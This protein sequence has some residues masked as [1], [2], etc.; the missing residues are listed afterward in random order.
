MLDLSV[1]ELAAWSPLVV[2]TVAIG[3]Y[4]RLVLGI[5]HPAV[6]ALLGVTP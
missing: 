3:V 6:V 5:T 4:P 2:L 1:A